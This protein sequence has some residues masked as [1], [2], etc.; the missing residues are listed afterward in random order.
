MSYVLFGDL[1][2][3][4][5]LGDTSQITLQNCSKEVRG[6]QDTWEFLLKKKKKRKHVVKHQ[7]IIPNH[8]NRHLELMIL[9]GFYVWE[10][11]G[12]WAH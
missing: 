12:V 7:R 9:V 11:T 4:Y 3:D 6:G 1:T 8:R 2:G 10:D 5:S